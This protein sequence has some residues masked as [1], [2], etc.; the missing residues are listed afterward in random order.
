MTTADGEHP[1]RIELPCD[2]SRPAIRNASWQRIAARVGPIAE[3]FAAFAVFVGKIANA[4]GFAIGRV[5]GAIAAQLEPDE[6]LH[7][8]AA[9]LAAT[10]PIT[11][12]SP[13]SDPARH[14]LFDVGF[15]DGD[16]LGD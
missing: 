4:R 3:G 7:A 9:R 1:D 13:S 12:L 5:S 6:S 16:P 10:P 15:G 14:P 11:G 2:R 8:L